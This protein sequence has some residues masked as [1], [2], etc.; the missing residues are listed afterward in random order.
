L[1][2]LIGTALLLPLAAAGGAA[3]A[4]LARRDCT[5]CSKL[6]MS[7]ARVVK[8]ELHC[9]LV[10]LSLT[11]STAAQLLALLLLLLLPLLLLLLLSALL[12]LS[13][14]ATALL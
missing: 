11:V 6:C 3:A 1:V 9:V 7:S 4:R 14:S 12:W 13:L 2:A 5:R 10:T 8:L